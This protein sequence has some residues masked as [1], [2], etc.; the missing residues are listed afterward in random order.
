[1]A[2]GGGIRAPLGT[3]SNFDKIMKK[4]LISISFWMKMSDRRFNLTN[5]SPNRKQIQ[6][7]L[8]CYDK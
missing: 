5:V 7:F 3:C 4:G 8:Y 1:M 2:P 6:D